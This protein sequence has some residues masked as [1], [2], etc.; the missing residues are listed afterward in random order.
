MLV[1]QGEWQ[2]F[3]RY[4]LPLVGQ[5]TAE[6]SEPSSALLL[7]SSSCRRKMMMMM[8]III[9]LFSHLCTHLFAEGFPSPRAVMDLLMGPYPNGR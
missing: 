7:E 3:S 8:I 2:F 1:W 6:G 5:C 4:V 9:I